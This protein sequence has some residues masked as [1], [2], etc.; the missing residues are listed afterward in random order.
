MPDSLNLNRIVDVEVFISPAAAPRATFNQLLIIGTASVIPTAERLREYSSVAEM[1]EDGFT[2]LDPEYIAANIYFNQS[3]SPDVVWIGRQDLASSPAESC[4]DAVQACRAANYEWYVVMV[5]GSA[6]ADHLEIAE[7]IESATPSSVYAYTTNDADILLGSGGSPPHIFEALKDLSYSRT[8]GQ[9]SSD[10]AYAIAAIMG[11]AMGQNSGLIDSAFT[12][13]FKGEVGINTESLTL[14]QVGYIE[15]ENGNVYLNYGNYYNVFEQ[16]VMADGS[17]FD[18]RI[19]LDMLV[20]NIQ[21]SV[22]DVLYQD[23]KVPQTE[24]GVTRLIHACQVACQ[25]SVDIGF[26][27]PGQWTGRN[28]LDLQVGDTLPLGYAV[29]SEA[30]ADQSDADRQL[31]KAPPIYVCI[32][33]AGAVHSVAIGVYVN[34]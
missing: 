8:I 33:E 27:A 20:N 29:M 32:K 25:T 31:R 17:F 26:L 3:P 9:Y 16:G 1:L 21:L 19:N 34:R 22:M 28:I 13:K 7:Y 18:E 6:Y 4:L 24:A 15:N 5:C 11:Y 30:I 23:P 12:L 10:S 14:T 2:I